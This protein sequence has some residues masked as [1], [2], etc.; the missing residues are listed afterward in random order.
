MNALLSI[1]LLVS[2]VHLCT[3]GCD[4]GTHSKRRGSQ[5][6]GALHPSIDRQKVGSLTNC[7]AIFTILF[8]FRCVDMVITELGV[9]ELQDSEMVLTE[10]GIFIPRLIIHWAY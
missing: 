7:G 1:Y 8:Y 4:N 10:I 3:G 5:A 6:A 2:N 9:F